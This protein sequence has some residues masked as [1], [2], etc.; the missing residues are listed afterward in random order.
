[1]TSTTTPRLTIATLSRRSRPQAI[2]VRD[3][4]AISVCSTLEPA[5]VSTAWSDASDMDL[6]LPLLDRLTIPGDAVRTGAANFDVALWPGGRPEQD[7]RTCP[8]EHLRAESLCC[9]IV[10][11]PRQAVTPS[12]IVPGHAWQTAP[13]GRSLGVAWGRR[14]SR[15][16][17]A[18]VRARSV[19][20]QDRPCGSGRPPG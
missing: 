8:P 1:M 9:T 7:S 4:P 12:G 3:R 14:Q 6:A 18:V 11:A 16:R 13:L 2:W 10:T 17:R 19:P 5:G 20:V 15:L